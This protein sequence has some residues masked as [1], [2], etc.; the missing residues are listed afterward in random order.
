MRIEVYYEDK[1]NPTILDVPDD[2]C[3][4]WVEDDYQRRLAEAEDK[5]TVEKRTVQQMKLS[6]LLDTI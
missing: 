2:Q 4:I 3:E 5:S 1:N 6:I